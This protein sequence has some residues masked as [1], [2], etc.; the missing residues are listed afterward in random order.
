ML[1]EPADVTT[2]TT[3]TVTY[4]VIWPV[5]ASCNLS[6]GLRKLIFPLGLLFGQMVDYPVY[7]KRKFSVPLSQL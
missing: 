5:A 4:Y 2:I 7:R 6:S 3:T 1:Q